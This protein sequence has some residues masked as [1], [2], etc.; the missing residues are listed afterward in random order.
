MINSR[1]NK[2][3]KEW[4]KLKKKKEREK[5]GAFLLE[6]F[7]LIE[8]AVKA[9]ADIREL[10]VTESTREDLPSEWESFPLYEVSDA[11]G[12]DIADTQTP[13]G[14]F[15]VVSAHDTSS[16]QGQKILLLDQVQDPGNLGTLIRSADAAGFDQVGLGK[17]T[18]D[19][20][21]QKVLRSAQGSHFHLSI[22]DVDLE[23]YIPALQSK[24]TKVY[25]TNLSKDSINYK[26]RFS[27]DQL[28][29]VVVNEGSGVSPSILALTDE[30]LHIP[31][32]GQ[33]E[34]LNVAIAAR[35]LMFHFN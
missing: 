3:V 15:A 21:N 26:E 28:A 8:E 12:L 32:K 14:I 18:V 17:G 6:G 23:D 20:Y 34:S 31:I 9:K 13:Q 1:Q 19:A 30:N 35:I 33:A 27:Q 7:H 29:I 5:Q 24:G 4:I 16:V 2:Q 25:G 11:I 22:I 10:I